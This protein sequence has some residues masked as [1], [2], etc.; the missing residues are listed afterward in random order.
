MRH[1]SVV[2]LAIK[3]SDI[4]TT[5]YWSCYALAN[6]KSKIIVIRPCENI[7]LPFNK[8][9]FVSYEMLI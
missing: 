1:F 3:I 4:E 7:K 6:P 5:C 8:T 9:S 2:G